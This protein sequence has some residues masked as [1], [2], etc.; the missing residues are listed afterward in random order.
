MTHGPR[1][2]EGARRLVPLGGRQGR[3]GT[4]V[5]TWLGKLGGSGAATRGGRV[6][7]CTVLLAVP[8]VAS[9]VQPAG[10]GAP[11]GFTSSLVL[12][13]LDAGVGANPVA[14]AYAPD[15]RVYIA[16][17]SGVIDVWDAGVR[18]TFFDIRDE[19][20][21]AQ[22]RGMLAVAVD[23]AYATNKRVFAIFTQEL[24]PANPDQSGPAGGEIISV[25][26]QTAH[27]DVGDPATRVTLLSG[28]QSVER[29]HTVGGL[30]FDAAGHLLATFGDAKDPGVDDGGALQAMNLDDLRGKLVRLDRN[31]G[32]G[33]PGNP[34]FDPANPT[35]VRSRVYAR[36]LRNAYRFTVDPDNGTL[37]VGDVG[38]NT[39]EMLNAFPVA[40]SNPDKDRNAGWPCYE[41]GNGVALPQPDFQY[42]P[43]S[44]SACA[45]VYPPS[46]GGTGIGV[47]DPLYG[48]RHDDPGGENGSAITAGPKYTGTS[49][50]PAQYV[51]KLFIGDY[52]RDRF[53]T[54]D[55]V[56][57]AA[58]D[59]GTPGDWGNPVDIQIAPDGN[60]AYLGIRSA[61][62]REIV[63]TGTNHVPVAVA[64]A[65]QTQSPTAPLTVSFTGHD[66]S[67]LDPGDTLTYDWDFKDGSAHATT[68]DVS[69]QFVAAGSYDVTLTVS[70]RHPGGTVS[71]NVWIDVANTPPTV[72]LT[73]PA[74]SFRYSIGDAIN[75][76][77]AA[78]DAEDGSLSGNSVFTQV[79]LIH[80]G[81][82]HP[83]LDFYGTSAS[84]TALDHDS[85]DTFYE[86]ISTATDSFG[87]STTTTTDILPNKTTVMLSSSASGATISVDGVQRTTPYSW[88]SI[89][90]GHH[91]LDAPA[92]LFVGGQPYAFD[93]WSQG[94]TIGAQQFFTFDTPS[95]G[96][97]VNAA[98]AP[99]TPGLSISDASVVEGDS[100][101][102]T[103]TLD[104]S[105]TTPATAP[106]TVDYATQGGS[107]PQ[108]ATAGSDYV[109]K[110]GTLS[111]AAGVS[112]QSVT[113]D[114]IGDTV[115]EGDEH[116]GVQLSNAQGAPIVESTAKVT[117]IDDDP[118]TG[119]RLSVG[120]VK[121][122]EGNGGTPS[123]TVTVSLSAPSPG[124]V[125]VG[126]VTADATATAP[127]DY[128]A[129]SGTI[130]IGKGKTSKTV[131]I[132][133]KGDGTFEPS[134]TFGLNLVS[135]VGAVI[136]RGAGTI[137]I[138][139]DDAG[140]ALAVSD[141]S[142]VEGD[143]GVPMV[144]FSIGLSTPATRT[145]AV[146]F[147]VNHTTTNGG[148]VQLK[149]GT[150]TIPAGQLD[151]SFQ[152]KTFSDT[153]T[154]PNETFAVTL[155]N[156]IN[157]ALADP[158]AVGTILNDDPGSGSRI[159]IGDAAINEGNAGSRLLRFT[160]T[161]SV[162]SANPVTVSYA[163]GAGTAHA[164]RDFATKSG[165]VTIPAGKTSGFIS[166][167][168]KGNAVPEP[169][170][171][172]SVTLSNPSGGYT[173]YRATGTAT[174]RNDD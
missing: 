31:T 124:G 14:F 153:T 161:L 12:S 39:W 155:S 98:Y 100:G 50:Y 156:P 121:V 1:S 48:Y 86:V 88:P 152:L 34:Y 128:A 111:F 47:A 78:N 171:T 37:Y 164:P 167:D 132:P 109:S 83:V 3:A 46:E 74:P 168:V 28:Y 58:S 70:D 166:I 131:T 130:S 38:W 137:R 66:S 29:E 110:T 162:P 129:R 147:A 4:T 2:L 71:T 102:R 173:L 82:F 84:F 112:S 16:R 117:I 105:L 106:V 25:R 103:V 57:G 120:D 18:H 91:E 148:D 144:I 123:A 56:T 26:A 15:G 89:V 96:T 122:L 116:F 99:T 61:E 33:V 5:G 158:T 101:N 139:N 85:D 90:G 138:A 113:V 145:V 22:S 65:D 93:Q 11:P 21:S 126:Y 169:D 165:A 63:Y 97:T 42:A 40:T 44:Q 118:G 94:T 30:R 19:V 151:Q 149:T 127:S 119:L 69:H 80:L 73:G 49:N 108:G 27:P 160:V 6:L 150:V 157:A 81:H 13:G 172:F 76:D 159:G 125:S 115:V 135:A 68:A 41:G 35:S 51:D 8:V 134:E 17:K 60:V 64:S 53:Q 79:R 104:V 55:P 143:S 95:G 140:P 142:I 170:K 114:V 23:P 107:A 52:A 87:R 92:D 77:L 9:D 24:D 36:G 7:V 146:S 43:A 54:V 141:V 62:L 154:E 59:F 163:T 45:A 20:N 32:A 133:I 174:I 10:A 136:E 72:A 67:D 75:L